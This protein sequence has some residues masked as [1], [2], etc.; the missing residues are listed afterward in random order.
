MSASRF[1]GSNPGFKVS[2]ARKLRSRI[3]E[4]KSR[5]T[6]SAISPM[7]R[8]PRRLL[9]ALQQRALNERGEEVSVRVIADR[10]KSRQFPSK[11]IGFKLLHSTPIYSLERFGRPF[12][13]KTC[14]Y[15][16]C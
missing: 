2:A 1:L 14:R 8:P 12:L 9:F 13:P 11:R 16:N 6:A 5:M 4:V 10:H 7:T 3:P 15:I